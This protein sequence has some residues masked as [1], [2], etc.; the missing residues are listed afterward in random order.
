MTYLEKAG[1]ITLI[2]SA[3][4]LFSGREL[5]SFYA[6]VALTGLSLGILGFLIGGKDIGGDI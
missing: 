4:I 6:A 3:V 1:L 2:I 5:S